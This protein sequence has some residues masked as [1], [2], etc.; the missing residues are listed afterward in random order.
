MASDLKASWFRPVELPDA[1]GRMAST[2]DMTRDGFT[3]LVMGYTGPKALAFKV[4]YIQ[5]F[6]EM[7]EELKRRRACAASGTLRSTL[8]QQT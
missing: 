7:E 3:L 5:K 8:L 6:N 4:A 1:Y 2:F